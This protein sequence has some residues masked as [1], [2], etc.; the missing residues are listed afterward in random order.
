MKNQNQQINLSELIGFSP[1]Q[2]LATEI[3]DKYKFTLYGG[4]AGGGKSYWLRWYLIRLLIKTFEETDIKGIVAGLFSEDYPTLKDRHVGKLEIEVPEWMGAVKEDKAYGLCLRLDDAL[5]KGVLV[6]RNLDDPS[7][8]MSTE[9]FAE[10][11]DEL[12]RNE[13]KV[14]DN[15]RS[16]LRWPGLEGKT[17]FVAGTN[18]GQIGHAWVK[19]LW[20]D[21]IYSPEEE[22]A[23][24][25][26]FV[27]AKAIDNPK[28]SKD[29]IKALSSLPDRMRRAL[30]EG[31]WDL[32]EG[33]FF[34]EFRREKHVIPTIVRKDMPNHW[35]NF[36][37]IDISGRNGITSCHWY[38][39]DGDGTVRAYREYYMAGLDS[40]EHARGIWEMSH[41]Q[42]AAGK[43]GSDEGYKYTMMDSSAW[44]K[45]GMQESIAEV[46]MRIW[47][48]LDN[49]H[50]VESSNVLVPTAKGK[51]S[52]V[53]GWDIMHQYLRYDEHHDP[54]FRIMENCPNLIRTIPLLVSDE[55]NPM[56]V[57]T[58]GEDHA[59]DD[60]R[61]L[62]Q[63]L[64]DQSVPAVENPV[65]R[66]MREM[67][68]LM[69]RDTYNYTKR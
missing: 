18:P 19:G 2:L 34:T 11:V 26:A 47:N 5:G 10:G 40:D 45:M 21:K 6:L 32:V 24:Q 48:E 41:Y 35:A 66:R 16:R 27:Q 52:R 29:Y 30:L 69:E 37:S 23:D 4:A 38:V 46:Y 56:D 65:Q 33:Q 68:E 1:K 44:F 17:K 15:L 49:K 20:I 25:F 8:Y 50:E 53:A 51:D 64:R 39:L 42:D 43:W 57:N 58:K 62:L 28:I 61:Y 67:K 9:F 12:T 36:R 22:E 55:K 63:T 31:D 3:A 59:P 60:T 14:F 54:Q 7:K 13:K